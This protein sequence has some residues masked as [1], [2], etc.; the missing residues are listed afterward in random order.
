MSCSARSEDPGR[1]ESFRSLV[2]MPTDAASLGQTL[3]LLLAAAWLLPLAGFAIE[4][5]ALQLKWSHRLSKA[6]AYLAVACIGGG[7]VLSLSALLMWGN[8][9]QWV[10]TKPHETSHHGAPASHD[11]APHGAHMSV[12][13]EQDKSAD[14]TQ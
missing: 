9:T 2:I 6:P 11:A 1:T 12:L 7:F 10:A 13:A 4:I 14:A 3:M 5:Y 8:K